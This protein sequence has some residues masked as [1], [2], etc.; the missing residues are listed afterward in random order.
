[1]TVWSEVEEALGDIIDDYEKVNHVISVFQD[2]RSRLIGLNK[3]GYN[4]G[5]A[6]ELGSGP[7]NYSRMISRFHDGPLVCLDYLDEMHMTAK[8]RNR[9]LDH[10]YIKG[11]FEALPIRDKSMTLVTAAYA[12]RDSLDKPK[13]IS[14]ACD[15]IQDSGKFLLIDIGK[16]DNRLIRKFMEVFIRFVVPVLGGLRAGYGIRNPWGKLYL[17][18]TKLPPNNDLISMIGDNVRI[19]ERVEKILGALVIVVGEKRLTQ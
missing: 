1:M 18:Y 7:G 16:P 17:T 9:G 12:I 6:L 10:Y 8:R 3:I 15:M 5:V 4:R 2:D 13:A 14:E 19:M 11:I